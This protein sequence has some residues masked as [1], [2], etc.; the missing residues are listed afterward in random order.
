M[1]DYL[2]SVITPCHNVNIF[3]LE[4][5]FNSIRNQT[6]G[7]DKIEWIVI[8]HNCAEKNALEIEAL[9]AGYP[10]V[11]TFRLQN[12]KKQAA[13]PRNYGI[14][15]ATGKYIAFL[16]ADD[17]NEPDA[18]E[19]ILGYFR[20]TKAQVVVTRYEVIKESP[21][22]KFAIR[23]LVNYNQT[24]KCITGNHKTLDGS[25]FIHG[26]AFEIG[27]KFYSREFLDDNKIRF[28][29]AIPYAE[30]SEFFLRCYG[31]ADTIC[32]LPQFISHFYCMYSD[33]MTAMLKKS[34]DVAVNYAK[35][36]KKVFDSGLNLNLYMNTFIWDLLGIYA[37]ILLAT[38]DMTCRERIEVKAILW[39]YFKTLTPLS[40]S[41]TYTK[42]KIKLMSNLVKL[43]LGHPRSVSV[44]MRLLTVFKI[45]IA[46]RMEIEYDSEF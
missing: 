27:S 18:F 8:I 14:D 4:R 44:V 38:M 1:K 9:T 24:L 43:V 35:G 20:E 21:D 36:F 19:V 39:P 17:Y 26:E 40:P 30:E 29:E 5:T 34:P 15:R 28:N 6:C 10:N 13:S 3:L 22:V 42:S 33:G 2:F 23:P 41:K 46:S 31:N 11:K 45:D 7:F 25:M 32:Y 16:D 37:A 12:D